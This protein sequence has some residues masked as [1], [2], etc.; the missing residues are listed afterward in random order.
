[1]LEEQRKI[2]FINDNL[3]SEF[4]G[5]IEEKYS[6]KSQYDYL[7]LFTGG[8]DSTFLSHIFKSIKTGR[9]CLFMLDNGYEHDTTVNNVRKL[10]IK[11]ECDIYI[12]SLNQQVINDFYSFLL[13]EKEL[14]E[15][16]TNPLCFFCSKLF[17][18]LGLE[19]ASRNDI[20]I[21]INGASAEQIALGNTLESGY[22][23]EMFEKLTEAKYKK[24]HDLISKLPDTEKNVNIKKC[25][26][27]IFQRPKN[28]RLL[29]PYLYLKYEI[30]TIKHILAE[31]YQ[32]CDPT[33]QYS[34]EE[35]WSTGCQLVGLLGK[36]DQIVSGFHSHEEEQIEREF[37][38]SIMSE[39]TYINWKEQ[40]EKWKT[41]PLSKRD[42]EILK[43]LGLI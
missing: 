26:E 10:A 28:V 1:M 25:F 3:K 22:E 29:Y 38:T 8:K 40:N 35:Y 18:A 16:D 12:R 7:I 17:C 24:I 32:W 23:I 14:L 9:V 11:L 6:E 2:E 42:K 27:K 19:F 36:L 13:Q 5:I 41:E 34:T 43:R 39:V 31:K 37:A 30:D 15:I 33:E 21:V 4:Y 20:P